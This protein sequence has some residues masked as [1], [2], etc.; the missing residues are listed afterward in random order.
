M[1]EKEIQSKLVRAGREVFD[2]IGRMVC[3]KGVPIV[4]NRIFF[5]TYQTAYTCN[6]KYI[7]EE[8][9]KRRLGYE[10]FFCVSREI[11]ENRDAYHIPKEIR[12][13]EQYSDES[14]RVQ[15][16]AA[17]WIDNGLN[18]I[19][20]RVPKRPGQIYLNTWH[21]S[22]GIKR[23]D[24]SR[25][26]RA[27]ARYGNRRI[28]YFLT[29]SVFDERVFSESFWPD[30]KHLKVGHPRNDI[31]FQK[32]NWAEIRQQIYLRY[33]IDQN[34]HTLLYAPTFREH[35]QNV[36]HPD[37]GKL[38]G[39][40]SERFGGVWRILLR[41]HFH[42]I[43]D[44]VQA[45][46]GT[47]CEFITDVSDYPDIQ[48]LM[49]AVD[50]GITDYS[51]WIFDFVFTGKP[52][53]LYTADLDCY[54]DERGFYYPLSETP[55]AVAEDDMRLCENIRQFDS[56]EYRKRCELFLQARGCYERGNASEQ[57]VN[58]ILSHTEEIERK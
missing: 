45:G 13:V 2:T 54:A 52:A 10:L 48:E 4:P 50:V 31:L 37:F 34:E 27:V 57:V 40:C 20:K 56:A 42:D 15:A 36:R 3:L 32:E 1:R 44:G 6:C 49:T 58:F 47:E 24:G 21:G 19:W 51:S 25:H 26:W 17:F 41:C 39:A 5:A 14:F 38:A 8:I 11:C 18:C 30:V 23:L 35:G 9:L 33:Q 22:L 29:D 46:G 12:L 16:S 43:G 7:A 53:F 28:D 55:F